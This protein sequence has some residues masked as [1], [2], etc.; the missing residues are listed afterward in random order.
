AGQTKSLPKRDD[1]AAEEKWDLEAIYETDENWERE[2]QEVKDM[3]P[4]ML[5]YKGKLGESAETLYEA[6]QLEDDITM[7]LGRLFTYAHMRSDE[8]TTNSF[9]QGLND[10]AASLAT[11]VG[12]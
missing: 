2:F 6:L 4:K 1:I 9:Y 11:N 12:R 5:D 3:L 10:R 8:D 7:K